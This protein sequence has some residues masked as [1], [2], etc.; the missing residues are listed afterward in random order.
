[1]AKLLDMREFMKWFLGRL[2]FYP[3]LAW[4]ILLYYFLHNHHWWDYI[5]EHVLIGG[6][7]FS[8]YLSLESL[9]IRSTVNMC[10]EWTSPIEKYKAK[11]IVCLN[12]PTFDYCIPSC[13][14]LRRGVQFIDDQIAN[15]RIVYVHCK[16]GR[17]RSAALVFCWLI[18]SKNMSPEEAQAYLLGRRGHV[19]KFL[20]RHPTIRQF[21][22]QCVSK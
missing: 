4:D 19:R 6:I 13:C 11:G 12:L 15:G 20:Y 2:F 7:P 10:E 16:A 8:H 3:T 22:L 14:D 9:G 1:M 18:H 17:G 21:Y 5:D